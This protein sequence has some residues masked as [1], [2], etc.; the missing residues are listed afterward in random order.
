VMTISLY[1]EK[2][3]MTAKSLLGRQRERA[4]LSHLLFDVRSGRSRA[5]RQMPVQAGTRATL[6]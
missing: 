4:A 6:S 3:M 2:S 5:L 1:S